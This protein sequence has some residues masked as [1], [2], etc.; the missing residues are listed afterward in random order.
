[1][2]FYKTDLLKQLSDVDVLFVA[3]LSTKPLYL[4]YKRKACFF[5]IL[6]LSLGHMTLGTLKPAG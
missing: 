5:Q 6:R 3:S 2:L 4:D 1:M